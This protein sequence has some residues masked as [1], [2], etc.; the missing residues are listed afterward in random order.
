ML[1]QFD[2]EFKNMLNSNRA[3]TQRCADY[4]S[5]VDRCEQQQQLRGTQNHS[6][7]T[8]FNEL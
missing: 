1:E 3:I 8:A 6:L 4:C 5:V 7:N 2:R